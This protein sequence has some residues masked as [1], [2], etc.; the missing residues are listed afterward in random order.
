MESEEQAQTTIDGRIQLLKFSCHETSRILGKN[1]LKP[2]ERHLKAIENQLDEIHSLKLSMQRLKIENGVTIEQV[3]EWT[4]EVEEQIAE[5]EDTSGMEQWIKNFKE[6]ERGKEKEKEEAEEEAKRQRQFQY[7]MKLE[8]ARQQM[9]IDLEKKSNGQKDKPLATSEQKIRVK[10]PKLEI[11]KFQG[12]HLDWQRFW[13]Q[14]EAEIDKA[15]ITQVAKFSYMKEL[16]DSKVRM[17]ID[18]LPFSSEGYERA[19]NILKTKYGRPSEVANAHIQCLIG[20]QTV[21]G[22]QPWK[23]H[24]FHDKLVINVQA[25]ET[26]GK[27]VE[28]NGYVRPILDKLPGIRADLVR[29]DDDWQEWKFPQ[30]VEALRKW[31][32]RNPIQHGEQ[33]THDHASRPPRREKFLHVKK[34]DRSAKVCVYCTSNS[35]K[36]SDCQAAK[37]VAE[38]KQHLRQNKLC[39]N[40]TGARHR[41]ND[42]HSTISCLRCKGRHHT[43][44]CDQSTEQM[45]LATGEQSVIYPVVVVKVDG[46]KCRALLDTGAGSSYIS[47]VLASNIGKRPIRKEIKQ[48]DMMLHSTSQK[49]DIY[50]VQISNVKGDFAFSTMVNRVDKSVLLSLPNPRYT[51]IIE[52]YPHM[53]EITMEDMDSKPEL[54]I[55]MVLGASDYTRIKT[56]TL[57]R[58]GK[59]GDPVAELTALGWTIMSPGKE[60]ELS[61]IYLTRSSTA[62]YEDLCRLDVLGIEDK[63]ADQ[64]SVYS[65]FQDQLIQHPDGWYETGLL[66]KLGHADLENNKAGS[67]GRLSSLLRKLKQN[68]SLF[69]QYN[70]VMQQQL[71]QQIIEKAPE[72]STRKEFYIPHRPVIRESAESTKVRIVYDASAK[73]S[74]KSPSLNECLETGPPL[75]NLLWNVLVR[76]RFKPVALAGDLKQAFL[77]IR[78]REEDR[79]AMRFHWIKDKDSSKVEVYRFTRAMFGLVQSPFLLG[80]TLEYHLNSMKEQHPAEVDEILRSLYVDDIITGM[81]TLDEVK[82]LKKSAV[83][84]FGKA[85]FQLHKWHSNLKELETEDSCSEVEQTFAKEQLGVKD[86][87]T[88][89]LGLKWNKASDTLRVEF[90]DKGAETTKRGILRYLAAIFDPLGLVAPITLKGKFVFRDAC[91]ANLPWDKELPKSLQQQWQRFELHLPCQFQ[92]PRSLAA[93]QENIEAIDLHVFGDTSGA[94]TATVMYA[95]V[96]QES[97]T[98]QGLVAAKARLAKKSLTIPRLELVSAHMAANLA[99]NVLDALQ[100]MPVRHIYGWLDSTVA[101][102]WIKGKGSYK[103]FVTNR[104]KKINEKNF[105]QWRYVPTNLNPA[106]IAS[107]GGNKESI[108]QM[109]SQG[110]LWLSDHKSWPADIQVNASGESEKEA[111]AVKEVLTVSIEEEKSSLDKILAKH[112]FWK[113]MHITAWI[114]R[115]VHNSR[116]KGSVR[117]VQTIMTEDLDM[118]INFW[119]KREQQRFQN[120]EEF[121]MDKQQ[122][123]L[124]KDSSDIFVCH[125]R[126]QGEYPQYLPSRSLLSEK[127]VMNAHINTLHGGVSLTMEYIR[128]SYWIPRLRQLTKKIIRSC[129][130]CKRFQTRSFPAPPEGNLPTDRT[131]GTRPFQVVGV[132]YAGPLTYRRRRKYEGKA[133][134]VLFACSLTRALYLEILPDLTTEEFLKC[135]KRFIARKGR[136]E[137][138]YS[139]NAK[140]FS[141]A[142]KWLK[143]VMKEEQIQHVLGVNHIKWQFN[144]SKAPW[145]GGQYERLV[146]LVKQSM[147]K[148]LGRAYLTWGE[149]EEVMLDVETTLNNRPLGYVEDDIQLP[150]LTP[151]M[152]MFGL[153]NHLPVED[154]SSVEDVGLRKRAR[155]LQRCKDSLWARWTGEYVRSLRERH[156]LKHKKNAPTIKE[157]EVVL[158]KGEERNRGRWKVGVITSLIVGRDG[159]VRAARVRTGKSFLERAIQHLYPLELS[160]DLCETQD[161]SNGQLNAQ[162]Q[163]FRPRRRAA[164]QAAEAVRVTLQEEEES[165]L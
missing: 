121:A 104:V 157:G 66:W 102:Y 28:V 68:P 76:N 43:S 21:H 59:L 97:G 86:D 106:D 79:D 23:I 162:A 148:T 94:G 42:C 105:I 150:I 149:L 93:F 13:S 75:Q 57:P 54:P 111:K 40:C 124:C 137:K 120:T 58:I 81:N 70:D 35:H 61:S 62:D 91:Q 26:M 12:T 17:S 48:I 50:D 82:H 65:E 155:Y 27:L 164:V 69:D 31:C 114:L 131:E 115:F 18:G 24:D 10:L 127:M 98:N 8:E 88:R 153:T 84:I 4:K 87:E 113:S 129:N 3:A 19:K 44:I 22:T 156:N 165:T 146:G 132:D 39:F 51:E 55:H 20:L 90:S 9:K 151:N 92:V 140:T 83:S 1:A 123:N 119:V 160:C 7:E 96:F 34:Q 110:P 118:A 89:L 116:K 77:Q 32:E 14:F 60:L 85:Q 73:P 56:K 107:R 37:T 45:L 100:G 152:M 108:G 136:P 74:E 101:L 125:G 63:S 109:W 135:L 143:K 138:I 99:Q 41:A 133:Y 15:E 95:V 126:I 16:I 64:D 47:G 117:K 144:L 71:A 46:I 36:S 29:M 6:K 159:V 134:I 53:Q 52:R 5:Y 30:L 80:G 139:D 142:A 161:S 11:T 130:W 103:Q 128:R 72:V 145:W 158:I 154:A 122:L 141:A 78:I 2:V 25:L 33:S 67:L 163:E 49:I 38:R 147:Y 112:G